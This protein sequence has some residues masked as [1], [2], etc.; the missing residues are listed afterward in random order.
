MPCRSAFQRI[1][2]GEPRSSRS[3][4]A[5]PPCWRRAWRG[6][7][8]S[9]TRTTS[10][11]TGRPPGERN[12]LSVYPDQDN[13]TSGKIELSDSSSVPI[14]YP[15]GSCQEPARKLKAS[16]IAS[17]SARLRKAGTARVAL[18]VSRKVKRRL[19]RARRARGTV[20]VTVTGADGTKQTG[21]KAVK[22]GR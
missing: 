20:K 3:P 2:A 6:R 7:P 5:P 10:S 4:S 18:K 16:R 22:L 19:T 15:G 13:T 14:S 11:S 8:P 12:S 1:G 21:A 17:G 9:A